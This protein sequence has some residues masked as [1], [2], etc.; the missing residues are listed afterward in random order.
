VKKI[1]GIFVLASLV[2][3]CATPKQYA[4][5]FDSQGLLLGEAHLLEAQRLATPDENKM[6]SEQ[7]EPCYAFFGVKS[8][9]ATARSKAAWNWT[10]AGLISGAV[11]APA[12]TAANAAAN[13]GW[14]AGFS[15]FSGASVLAV[16]NANTLG[17]G[18]ESSANGMI[19]VA[20]AVQVPIATASNHSKPYNEREQAAAYASSICKIPFLAPDYV[21]A[22]DTDAINTKLDNLLKKVEEVEQ[23]QKKTNSGT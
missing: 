20:K 2:A 23:Q 4:P 7:I 16:S 22:V 10:L 15:G 1:T 8:A 14:I 18:P 17:I 9:E 19:A 5:G 3:A 12:L 21:K 13:A 11:I 6:L